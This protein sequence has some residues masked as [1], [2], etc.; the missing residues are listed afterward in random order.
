MPQL[1]SRNYQAVT[2]VI[3][4]IETPVIMTVA[5][6]LRLMDY[7]TGGQAGS[8]V[9]ITPQDGVPFVVRVADIQKIEPIAKLTEVKNYV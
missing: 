8:H 9:Q 1:A 3:R 2:V 5:T 7:L 6:G 4:D